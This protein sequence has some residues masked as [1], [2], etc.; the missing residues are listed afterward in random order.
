M[1]RDTPS[2]FL[3]VGGPGGVTLR[4][5]LDY[6][7]AA[8]KRGSVRLL[9]LRGLM[10]RRS[11]RRSDRHRHPYAG[12]EFA[13][14]AILRSGTWGRSGT[15]APSQARDARAAV[16]VLVPTSCQIESISLRHMRLAMLSFV[17]MTCARPEAVLP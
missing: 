17:R 15:P 2:A 8:E 7:I 5:R 3:L 12:D 13:V 10:E 16:F 9:R 4:R 6:E 11:R 1:A 14:R